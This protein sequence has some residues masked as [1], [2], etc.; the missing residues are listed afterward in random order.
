MKKNTTIGKRTNNNNAVCNLHPYLQKYKGIEIKE[1]LPD[2]STEEIYGTI[3][4]REWI[5][6][7]WSNKP[8]LRLDFPE[9]GYTSYASD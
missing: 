6:P 4:I 2:S 1:M 5:K 3:L 7:D 9:M 8:I